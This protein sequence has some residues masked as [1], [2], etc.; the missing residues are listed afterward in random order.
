VTKEDIERE[1]GTNV[2]SVIYMSQA[3]VKAGHMPQ[4][5]RIINIGSIASKTSSAG[6]SLYNA[7]KSAQDSLTSGLASDV[8]DTL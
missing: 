7:S 3:V 1:F 5:G 8:S 6:T 4:G 2:F